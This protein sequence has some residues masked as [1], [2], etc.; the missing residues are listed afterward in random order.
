MSDTERRLAIGMVCFPSLGGSGVVASELAKGLA[1]RGHRLHLIATSPPARA[2]NDAVRFHPV[3]VTDYPL[4]EYP[5]YGLALASRL[6]RVAEE[7]K[8][9]CFHMHYAVPHAASAYLAAQM[10]GKAA[11]ANVVSLHGTDVT[12]VGAD[13]SYRAATAFAVDAADAVT[14][15]SAFLKE[16]AYGDL[17]LSPSTDV[18][19]IPN[20]VDS[21][22][23]APAPSR[24][25]EKL[26]ALFADSHAEPEGPILIHVSNFRPIK[27]VPELLDVLRILRQRSAAKLIL[28]GDGPERQAAQEKARALGLGE[29][30][31]FLGK[32]HDF[33]TL[34]PH[35]D[36]FLLGSESESFGLAALEAL[37][38]GV[39]VCAYRVGGL[40]EVV[41][42]EVGRLAP[43]GEPG[44]LAEMAWT[45]LADPA[46]LEAMRRAARERV[47]RGY[48][49]EPALDRFEACYRKAIARREARR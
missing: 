36:L 8:L 12:R 28:V 45:L 19:V 5:P 21:E 16:A 10:L 2:P 33:H 18:E 23:F 20:F 41:T 46:R 31:R 9:D 27:R 30:V 44:A 40:P 49:L 25:P 13:P 37:A 17:G 3:E 47:E 39:P 22:R 15:P 32:R 26:R 43:M 38:C 24:E 11:P 29:A 42:E 34:L 35:A 1:R 7:E 4:F 6:A 48:R 14:T